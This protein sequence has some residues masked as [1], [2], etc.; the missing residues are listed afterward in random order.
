M[1]LLSL[2]L[3][4]LF[5]FPFLHFLVWC[6]AFFSVENYVAI[7][8]HWVW[9]F[10][11]TVVSASRT[12]FYFILNDIEL[13]PTEVTFPNESSDWRYDSTIKWNEFYTHV[14]GY[15]LDGEIRTDQSNGELFLLFSLLSILLTFKYFIFGRLFGWLFFLY[16]SSV[17]FG[18]FFSIIIWSNPALLIINITVLLFLS[19]LFVF[20]Y[21][22]PTF[23]VFQW[24]L[25]LGIFISL[26]LAILFL[27]CL[28]FILN[29]FLNDRERL[30]S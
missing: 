16:V 13:F 23:L 10:R 26:L 6:P 9:N 2:L 27:N 11:K 24:F 1:F 19:F 29:N 8:V 5:L 15:V 21:F 22:N 18:H 17:N 25:S 30:L 7:H 4:E 28:F 20:R 14:C 12:K 3:L